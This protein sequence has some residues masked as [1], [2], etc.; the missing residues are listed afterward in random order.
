MGQSLKKGGVSDGYEICKCMILLYNA[1]SVWYDRANVSPA[2]A[3]P[4]HNAALALA[5][6]QGVWGSNPSLPSLVFFL[7]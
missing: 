7:K 6:A 5:H 1:A 3:T 4:A 2:R